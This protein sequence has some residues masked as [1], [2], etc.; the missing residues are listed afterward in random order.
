MLGFAQVN[1]LGFPLLDQLEGLHKPFEGR[2][3]DFQQ[4]TSYTHTR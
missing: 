1:E 3:M 4:L 2:G